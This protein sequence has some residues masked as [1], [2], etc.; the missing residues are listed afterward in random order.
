ML[1]L[2]S[3]KNTTSLSLLAGWTVT[4]VKIRIFSVKECIFDQSFGLTH[5]SRMECFTIINLTSFNQSIW[6]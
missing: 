1:Y 6:N 3:L 5:L 2:T 4:E